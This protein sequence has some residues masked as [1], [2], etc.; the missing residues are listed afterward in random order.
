MTT[1]IIILVVL[2]FL[3]AFFSGA[4]VALLAITFVRV[5]LL[6]KQ[7]RKGAESLY[8]LKSHPRRMIITILIGNNVVN[9]GAASLATYV[10]AQQFGSTGVGIATGVLTLLILIFGEIT[11]KTFAHRYASKIAPRISR[12]IEIFQFVLYPLVFLLNEQTKLM[13]RAVHVKKFEPISEAEIKEM[14]SFGVEH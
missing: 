12:I 1:Y 7:R 6:R 2:I 14:V 13:E 3:S 4:E 9:I 8:R 10:S 5:R 11:P